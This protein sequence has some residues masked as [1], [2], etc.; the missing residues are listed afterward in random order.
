MHAPEVV[1]EP[2]MTPKGQKPTGIRTETGGRGWCFSLLFCSRVKTA[3]WWKLVDEDQI[4]H[5]CTAVRCSGRI[6]LKVSY[7]IPTFALWCRVMT[8]NETI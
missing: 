7:S 1:G 6:C 3:A 2:G 8:W 5:K 4:K